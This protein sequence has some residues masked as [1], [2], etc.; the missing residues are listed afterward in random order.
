MFASKAGAYLREVPCRYSPLR[1]APV[2]ITQD[3]KGLPRT[4]TLAHFGLLKSYE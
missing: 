1:Y 4:N 2:N 3:W